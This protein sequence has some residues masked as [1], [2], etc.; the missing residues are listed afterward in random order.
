MLFKTPHQGINQIGL[1]C[2]T[3]GGCYNWYS[4]DKDREQRY[5]LIE[6]DWP[7]MVNW[8]NSSSCPFV[9][10]PPLSSFTPLL[11]LSVFLFGC[12]LSRNLNW[13]WKASLYHPLLQCSPL[14]SLCFSKVSATQSNSLFFDD[15]IQSHLQ[16]N[17]RLPL[18]LRFISI[19][20]PLLCLPASKH[21]YQSAR[22]TREER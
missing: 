14:R 13:M 3:T 9:S 11:V 21:E 15:K 7:V 2:N 6:S 10:S 16:P 4:F 5:S 20:S 17:V 18:E 1:Y 19:I 12:I 22:S 8:S